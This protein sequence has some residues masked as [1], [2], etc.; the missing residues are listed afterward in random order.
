MKRFLSLTLALS[1]T[2]SLAACG[3][4]QKDPPA[5]A[6]NPPAASSEAPQMD[7]VKITVVSHFTEDYLSYAALHDACEEIAGQSNGLVSFEYYP[8]EQMVKSAEEWDAVETGLA[9]M[10]PIFPGSY[11]GVEPML[12]AADQPFEYDDTEHFIRAWYGG[13]KDIMEEVFA[14]HNMKLLQ[15]VTPYICGS[16]IYTNKQVKSP[17]DLAGQN[18]RSSSAAASNVLLAGGASPVSMSSSEY[19]LALS[20]HTIDGVI[21][22]PLPGLE[23]SVQEVVDYWLDV[24]LSTPYDFVVMNLDTWNKMT[25]DIQQLFIDAFDEDYMRAVVSDA[26]EQDAAARKTYEEAGVTIYTPTDDERAEWVA[27]G[28]SVLDTFLETDGV[29]ELGEQW[30]KITEE[31]RN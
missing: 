26:A 31:T 10:A 5:D 20:N 11:T 18:I 2:L 25:P 3:G 22:S 12:G 23:R 19:Y 30:F 13:Q 6:S 9:D 14:K 1:L 8:M 15:V 17:A 27:L 4:G 24:N 28:Q 21:T 7:P 16:Q 29:G